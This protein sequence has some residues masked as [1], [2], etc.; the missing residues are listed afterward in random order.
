ML[1]A[2]KEIIKKRRQYDCWD[3]SKELPLETVQEILYEAHTFAAKKQNVPH[4]EIAVVSYDDLEL[5]DALWNY[6]TLWEKNQRT[7]NPQTLA[8]Y[9]IV[10]IGKPEHSYSTGHFHIGIHA[11]FIAHAAAARGLQTGFCQ[12]TD[13]DLTPEQRNYILEKLKIADL[14]D[15]YLMLGL[16]HGIVSDSMIHPVSGKPVSTWARIDLGV[17]PETPPDQY[18]KFL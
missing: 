16:G 10:F 8:H 14:D 7:I 4:M 5:R 12:C 9:L 1:E 13:D 6:S 15:I 2:W 11:D 18:I 17:D 3:L